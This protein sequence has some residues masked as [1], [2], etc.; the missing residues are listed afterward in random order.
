MSHRYNARRGRRPVAGTPNTKAH[1]AVAYQTVHPD[2]L[3][4]YSSIV[5]LPSSPL[6]L[7]FLPPR[8]FLFGF[9]CPKALLW[10]MAS[11]VA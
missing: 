10:M 9:M 5:L 2:I 7:A 1:T 4:D 6:Q 8:P 3:E 11:V